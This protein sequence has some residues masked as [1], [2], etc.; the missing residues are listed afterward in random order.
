MDTPWLAAEK[1]IVGELII[2]LM[3]IVQFDIFAQN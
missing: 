1:F 3:E 2:L